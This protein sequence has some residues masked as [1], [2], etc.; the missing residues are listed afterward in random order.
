[1]LAA[2]LNL[3]VVDDDV[4]IQRTVE[5][6]LRE[7]SINIAAFT[8]SSDFLD[9]LDHLPPGV[10]LLDL[11]MP[12]PGGLAVQA[13]I[14][15]RGA[16]QAVV[17]LSGGGAA[18]EIVAAVRAGAV[19]YLTKPFRR[20]DLLD[21]LER[22]G[23]KLVE[24][25]ESQARARRLSAAL[26]LSERERQVLQGLADG[27]QSKTIAHDLGISARTVEMHRANIVDKLKMPLP[28]ALLL[29]HEAGIIRAA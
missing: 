24:L 8:R 10:V 26:A 21:A 5:A 13:E 23:V 2:A 12:A 3:S 9:A 27:G 19:D 17:F 15:R 22:A 25:L 16:P 7:Q 18:A 29:A 4:L 20:A 14:V 28:G 11:M 1:M 6:T